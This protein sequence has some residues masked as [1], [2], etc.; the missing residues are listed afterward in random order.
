MSIS[1][2]DLNRFCE[3]I[4]RDYGIT[5][6]ICEIF[7]K[8]WSYLAGYGDNL[9]AGMRIQINHQYGVVVDELP[10]HL[11]VDFITQIKNFLKADSL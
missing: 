4:Y 10:D 6:A 11:H 8:R 1:N 7:G 3:E 5:L 2:A 9:F